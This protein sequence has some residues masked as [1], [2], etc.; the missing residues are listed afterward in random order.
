MVSYKAT[1]PATL[2]SMTTVLWAIGYAL[3]SVDVDLTDLMVLTCVADLKAGKNDKDCK[4]YKGDVY[5]P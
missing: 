1:I 4:V 5:T 3:C 2:A